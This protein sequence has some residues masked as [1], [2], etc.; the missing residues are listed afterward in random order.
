MPTTQDQQAQLTPD[1]VLQDL[2]EGNKRFVAAAPRACDLPEALAAAKAGQHPKAFVLG[3]VD[4]RVMV[5]RLFDQDMGDIFVGRVAGNVI[6][7]AQLASMEFATQVA[8]A[9]LVLVLGHESCGAV[10]GAC[11]GV[12]LGHLTDLLGHIR[13]AILAMIVFFVLGMVLLSRVDL[14]QAREERDAWAFDGDD[15]SVTT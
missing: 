1:A 6:D 8:G 11:A 5:E 10:A 4:S 9:K 12:D 2:M 7:S 14:E 15:V 3:C 13:P